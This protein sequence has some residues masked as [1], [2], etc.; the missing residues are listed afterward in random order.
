[1]GKFQRNQQRRKKTDNTGAARQQRYRQNQKKL[2]EVGRA[3]LSAQ[4]GAIADP[5]RLLGPAPAEVERMGDDWTPPPPAPAAELEDLGGAVHETKPIEET[6]AGLSPDMFAAVPLAAP[7]PAPEGEAPTPPIDGQAP[8]PLTAADVL[9]APPPANEAKSVMLAG[10]LTGLVDQAAQVA[11]A[12]KKL[13]PLTPLLEGQREKFVKG[14]NEAAVRVFA[15]HNI[16]LPYED[17]IIVGGGALAAGA[18]LIGAARDAKEAEKAQQSTDDATVF[19]GDR[20]ATTEERG[21]VEQEIKRGGWSREDDELRSRIMR[22][23]AS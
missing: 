23:Q 20:P 12:G 13:G 5:A 10:F 3:V 21:Q 9:G 7:P 11:I 4:P 14:Y 8:A 6:T 1:M 15:K 17:E 19:I 18:I 22:G 16:Q 2:A